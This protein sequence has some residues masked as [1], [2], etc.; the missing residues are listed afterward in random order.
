MAL[1]RLPEPLRRKRL[2]DR[3]T[4][5][6]EAMTIHDLGHDIEMTCA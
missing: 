4:P 5:M 1:R 2:P 6:E 3:I